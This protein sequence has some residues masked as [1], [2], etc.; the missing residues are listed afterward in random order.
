MDEPRHRPRPL[1]PGRP[2]SRASVVAHGGVFAWKDGREN[3]DTFQA[4]LEYPKGFLVSYSTSFGNDADS[5]TRMMGKQAT[6]VNI[7][8]EGSPRWKWVEEKGT[9]EDD[10]NVK[11]AGA[12]GD[13]AGRRPPGP[14]GIG[15]EDPSH[16][17]NW[18]GCLRSRQE[19]N[20]TVRDG[21]A[22]SVACIM[23]AR[24]QREGRKLWWDAKAEAIVEQ[25]PGSAA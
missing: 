25:R 23:A 15:D 1:L 13:A 5:F 21:F 3:P 24:A 11:R 19:P 10:P 22:H 9:H 18:L 20:A 4:L 14:T 8:G 17:T 16:M 6:L 2:R 12:L 7:G